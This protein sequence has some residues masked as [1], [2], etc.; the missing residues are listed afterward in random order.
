M[1]HFRTRQMYIRMLLL[2]NV[3]AAAASRHATRSDSCDLVIDDVI[4]VRAATSAPC[5]SVQT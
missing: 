3:C 4:A 1:L 5:S 2:T